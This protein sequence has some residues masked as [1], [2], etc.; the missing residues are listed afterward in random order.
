MIIV[1]EKSIDKA[2]EKIEEIPEE[3]IQDYIDSAAKLQP[4]VI[5][6]AMAAG[7]DL[8]LEYAEDILYYTLVIWEAFSEEAGNISEVAENIIIANEENYIKNLETLEHADDF[9]GGM[10]DMM[11]T[12]TQP[13]LLSFLVNNLIVD[14]DNESDEEIASEDGTIFS[15]LQII[16]ESFNQTVNHT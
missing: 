13:A 9:E 4:N 5:T 10:L 12:T 1:S 3:S 14:E 8:K 2:I 15:T 6:Y 16:I 11:N 7:N